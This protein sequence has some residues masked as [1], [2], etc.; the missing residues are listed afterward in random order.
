MRFPQRS[1]VRTHGLLLGVVLLL[2]YAAELTTP[3]LLGRSGQIKGAD[4]SN[5]YVLGWLA[6]ND[7][8]SDLYDAAALRQTAA[9][10]LPESSDTFYLPIYGPQVALFFA[11]FARLPYEWSLVIW[12]LGTTVIYGV[13]VW[14]IWRTCPSLKRE[15]NA[16]LL[17]AASFPAFFNLITHG[18]NSAVALACF[19]AAYLALRAGRPFWAGLAIGSLVFKPQL[20]LAAALVFLINREWRVVAGAVV[21]AGLQLWGT[22]L[23]FGTNVMTAYGQWLLGIGDLAP[24]LHVK[25][26]QMHSLYSFW[27]LLIPWDP[28]A[29]IFYGFTAGVVIWAAC[30]VWR[31]GASISLR[32][33]FLLLATVLV[34]PHLYVY[35][36]VILAPAF[37]IVGDWT[38]G[39]PAGPFA[40]PM[41]R[42]LYFSYALPL[43]GAAAQFTRLQLSVVAFLA[44]SAVLGLAVFELSDGDN[45]LAKA[46]RAGM[47]R[48]VIG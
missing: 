2:V 1:D 16:V 9:A 33:A 5:F 32:Y 46:L 30:M 8:A 34:S 43:A 37:L 44:L 35:D 22:W 10:L 24:L 14:L 47:S 13:C 31:S 7:R 29:L 41:Q 42:T 27:K 39:Q 40:K 15:A 45:P 19:T 12:L 17:L 23:Y 11:T 48:W 36:L 25:P 6:L 21:A 28:G 18:Q 20:G 38:L 4:F 26:Y 3:T